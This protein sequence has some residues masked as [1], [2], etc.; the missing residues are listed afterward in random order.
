[1]KAFVNKDTCI[2]CELCTQICPEVFSMDD[3]GKSVAIDEEI[4]SENE[5]SAV[6]AR[7]S[8]PVSAID[9]EYEE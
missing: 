9:I 5:D 6:E 8:C 2:A 7:D 3:D 4:K 1:M